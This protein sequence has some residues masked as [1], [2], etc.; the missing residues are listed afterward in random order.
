MAKEPLYDRFDS[1]LHQPRPNPLQ[2]NQIRVSD[3]GAQQAYN[4]LLWSN[5]N[6]Q[7]M[8]Y[9]RLPASRYRT[10]ESRPVHLQRTWEYGPVRCARNDSITQH[11]RPRMAGYHHNV[12]AD[13]FYPQNFLFRQQG[14]CREEDEMDVYLC[15]H[16]DCA[17]AYH[18]CHRYLPRHGAQNVGHGLYLLR[19]VLL[20]PHHFIHDGL[21][22]LMEDVVE[23]K[24]I[25]RLQR[26]K[27]G[28]FALV[29]ILHTGV[30]CKGHLE[31]LFHIQSVY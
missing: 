30:L 23:V 5:P 2:Y 22:I 10:S 28:Y 8:P 24:G 13:A 3:E 9:H 19:S 11:A 29:H 18:T 15:F 14:G 6:W 4:T 7:R 1:L 25:W 27:L 12:P 17:L 26:S 31:H 20:H 16:M 21:R